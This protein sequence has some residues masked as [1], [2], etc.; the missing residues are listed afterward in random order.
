MPQRL[1]LEHPAIE[2]LVDYILGRLSAEQETTLDLHFAD[3]NSCTETARLERVLLSVLE[4]WTAENH[5]LARVST[6]LAEGLTAVSALPNLSEWQDRLARWRDR[7][8]DGLGAAVRLVFEAATA[9]SLDI[10]TLKPLVNPNTVFNFRPLLPSAGPLIRGSKPSALPT[11]VALAEGPGG[12]QVRIEAAGYTRT[13]VLK[14]DNPPR[15]WVPPLVLLLPTS[16]PAKVQVAEFRPSVGRPGLQASFVDVPTGE[17]M[18]AF[19]PA[20]GS[21]LDPQ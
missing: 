15:G 14:L 2:V 11:T 19:E 20:D 13:V 12:C 17:Y 10:N 9:A 4:S 7:L 16:S 8:A 6:T 3:C 5:R 21:R 18:L 1:E